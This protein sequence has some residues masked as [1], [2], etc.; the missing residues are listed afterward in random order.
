MC[1]QI[2]ALKPLEGGS[3]QHKEAPPLPEKAIY[4]GE[5]FVK[6]C[7][8]LMVSKTG[9]VIGRRRVLLKGRCNGKGYRIV[10]YKGDKKWWSNRYVHRMVATLFV[11]NP[12]N[13]SYVN[14]LDGDKSNNHYTNLE[15]V[16]ARENTLHAIETGLL[17]NIPK[18]GQMGFQRVR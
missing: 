7:D 15:W 1:E 8:Y 5:L 16:T 3:N 6:Y 13:K 12:D 9:K 17:G 11:P 2:K 18:K 4:K 10:S 14:H